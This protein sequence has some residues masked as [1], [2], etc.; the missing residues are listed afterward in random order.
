MY[1]SHSTWS[2][3]AAHC[4]CVSRAERAGKCDAGEESIPALQQARSHSCSSSKGS[5]CT[6]TVP[7]IWK[8]LGLL[9]SVNWRLFPAHFLSAVWLMNQNSVSWQLFSTKLLWEEFLASHRGPLV[10]N[11]L[12]EELVWEF[13]P[14][15]EIK[16]YAK[17]KFFSQCDF[18]EGKKKKWGWLHTNPLFTATCLEIKSL[19]GLV[20]SP[21]AYNGKVLQPQLL[22]TAPSVSLFNF[23]NLG[24][25]PGK[26]FRK[27]QLSYPMPS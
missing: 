14:F 1:Q 4:A 15:A 11:F 20:I 5:Q 26:D 27:I 9:H 10:K 18:E 12:S 6:E 19:S 22:Y 17:M 7:E 23:P 8:A 25:Y 2:S 24:Y 21:V 13:C 3:A 16:P